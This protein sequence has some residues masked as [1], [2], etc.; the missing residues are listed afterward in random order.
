[1]DENNAEISVVE[2]KPSLGDRLAAALVA[3]QK[4]EEQKKEER[5]IV[6][7]AKCFSLS[8]PKSLEDLQRKR[9]DSVGLNEKDWVEGRR[10]AMMARFYSLYCLHG[11]TW[12]ELQ[13]RVDDAW[14]VVSE[15]KRS[16]NYGVSSKP[17]LSDPSPWQENAVR[18]MEDS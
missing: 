17:M 12:E 2:R 14:S 4:K 6:M 18:A 15:F 8:V 11:E 3:K 16:Y 10:I 1:M 13:K 9:E 7:R 5:K